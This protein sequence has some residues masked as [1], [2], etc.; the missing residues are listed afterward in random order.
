M[1][2]AVTFGVFDFF[3]YGHL[4]LFE[5]AK[6]QT[7]ADYLIVAVQDGDY[8]LKYKPQADILYSTEQRIELVRSLSIV[9]EVIVY[10]DVDETIKK[11]EFDVLVRGEDQSHAG[12][13]RASEYAESIGKDVVILKRTKGISSSQIKHGIMVNEKPDPT[14]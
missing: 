9:D 5:H 2:K 10:T 1:K 14:K 7:G 13:I 12:F 3:H 6:T 4:K 11:I 8:I